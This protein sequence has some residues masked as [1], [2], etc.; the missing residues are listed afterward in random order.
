MAR[1]D[2][3]MVGHEG[4]GNPTVLGIL[5]IATVISYGGMTINQYMDT[6]SNHTT[7]GHGTKYVNIQ[8]GFGAR[9]FGIFSDSDGRAVEM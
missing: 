8:I 2:Q 6:I 4:Y 1:H 9:S 7:C 3:S 5:I